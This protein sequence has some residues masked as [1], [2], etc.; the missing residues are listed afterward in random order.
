M[1][2][3]LLVVLALVLALLTLVPFASPVPLLPV[4]VILLC[5]AQLR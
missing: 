5:I 1:N 4:A 3:K 2:R